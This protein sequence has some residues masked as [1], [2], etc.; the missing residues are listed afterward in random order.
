MPYIVVR[1][2]HQETDRR[3]LSGMLGFGRAPECDVAVRDISLSRRHCRIDETLDGWT[4][5]DLGSKNGTTVNGE[6]LAGDPRLL[7]DGDIV[8]LGQSRIIFYEGIPNEDI[9]ERLMS[10]ARPFDPH[11]AL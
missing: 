5:V 7:T 6:A 10:P 4:I 8:R 9:A 11:E 3:E 2:N 1:T